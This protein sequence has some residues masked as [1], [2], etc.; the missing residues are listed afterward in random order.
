MPFKTASKK[1]GIPRSTLQDKV[2]GRTQIEKKSGPETVLTKDEEQL[3]VNSLFHIA[4]CG[5]PGTKDQLLDNVELLVKNLERPNKFTDG[6]PGLKWYEG[7]LARHPELTKRVS[8]NL[9]SSRANLSETRIRQWFAEVETYL[10]GAGYFELTSEPNRVFNWDETAF[11]LSPKGDKVLVRRGDKTVYSFINNDEK[12]CLT[13]LITCSA[14]GQLPPPMIIYSYKRVPKL[15]TEK[16]PKNWGIGR[17][18]NGW[19]T[20]ESFFQY[21]ANIFYPWL[22]EQKI[23]FPVILFMDGLLNTVHLQQEDNNDFELLE[24]EIAEGTLIVFQ[25]SGENW[26][27]PVGDKNLFIIWKKIKSRLEKNTNLTELVT[28]AQSIIYNDEETNTDSTELVPNFEIQNNQETN[29]DLTELVPN[30]EIQQPNG[31]TEIIDMLHVD[32]FSFPLILDTP[33]ESINVPNIDKDIDD[34]I[35]MKPINV[36]NETNN[37]ID[38]DVNECDTVKPTNTVTNEANYNIVP[39]VATS[40]QWQEYFKTKEEKKRIEEEQKLKRKQAKEEKQQGEEEKKIQRQ[41]ERKRKQMELDNNRKKKTKSNDTH[42]IS[43]PSETSKLTS[44]QVGNG[45]PE[46]FGTMMSQ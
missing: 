7:F 39:A 41:E 25:S 1:Y 15:V 8:Q 19:M 29:E 31:E 32:N 11:F 38:M 33:T 20:G 6:R 21:I 46:P 10:R 28:E 2:K 42:Q 14:S 36:I 40:S 4:S 43:D 34:R 13:T 23:K 18:E 5:F 17:S 30:Y 35:T 45:A 9:T 16:V 37:D 12:E 27:G 44:D 26:E 3:L 24:S 22:V